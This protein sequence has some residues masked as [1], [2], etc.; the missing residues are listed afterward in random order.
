MVV[1]RGDMTL[2][3]SEKLCLIHRFHSGHCSQRWPRINWEMI[4]KSQWMGRASSQLNQDVSGEVWGTSVVLQPS[5]MAVTGIWG[6]H[7]PL[8]FLLP[9]SGSV[10]MTYKRWEGWRDGNTAGSPSLCLR[11]LHIPCSPL[12]F[13]MNCEARVTSLFLEPDSRWPRGKVGARS[14]LSPS[15]LL[16]YPWCEHIPLV[17]W[18]SAWLSHLSSEGWLPHLSTRNV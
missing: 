10:Q 1:G 18:L 11:L 9:L 5:Q 15:W 8:W 4:V 7:P 2:L 12:T 3:C 6:Y 14:S 16:L 13:P 17:R